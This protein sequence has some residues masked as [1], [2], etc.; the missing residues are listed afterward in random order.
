MS[1]IKFNIAEWKERLKNGGDINEPDETGKIALQ[2]A[3]WADSIRGIKF[4]IKHGVD[5]NR[6]IDGLGLSPL[7]LACYGVYAKPILTLI[8]LGAKVNIKDK[9][10]YSPLYNAAWC[11]YDV[12]KAFID[13][14]ADVNTRDMSGNTILH[15][16]AR[17]NENPEVIRLLI[18]AGADINLQNN[19]CETPLIIA[20]ISNKNPEIVKTLLDYGAD[21][22]I[23]NKYGQTCFEVACSHQSKMLKPLLMNIKDINTRNKCAYHLAEKESIQ[24]LDT[25]RT[26]LECGIDISNFKQVFWACVS[27]F[28][29]T[30]ILKQYGIKL[31]IFPDTLFLASKYYKKTQTLIKALSLVN[32][33]TKNSEGETALFL[34]VKDNSFKAVDTLLRAGANVNVQNNKAETPL[35][36]AIKYKVKDKIFEKLLASGAKVN[37][38]DKML[39]SAIAAFLSRKN[40][41]NTSS[42]Q[43]KLFNNKERE[44]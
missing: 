44:K 11:P 20:C 25:V 14:G 10:G 26:L 3:I 5:I 33:N 15:A 43:L 8:R 39:Q 19:E 31:N 9:Q 18:N 7:E 28:K 42:T 23:K 22:N 37:G 27:K 36:F 13:A 32:I 40:N 17:C 1:E 4:C 24:N 29:I 16:A 6:T 35:S 2:Q 41:K 38:K 34:A 12:I 21:V 30:Q